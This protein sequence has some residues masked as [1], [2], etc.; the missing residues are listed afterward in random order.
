MRLTL[1][2]LLITLVVFTGCS[3]ETEVIEPTVVP[4][5]EVYEDPTIPKPYVIP[6]YLDNTND[7][8]PSTVSSADI[9]DTETDTDMEE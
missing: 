8:N 4:V 5:E 9:P 2:I 3:K 6:D 7:Y 1:C